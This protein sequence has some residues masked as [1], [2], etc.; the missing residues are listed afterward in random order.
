MDGT[1]SRFDEASG[2]GVVAGA[3][4]R[5]YPFHC[6]QLVDGTRAVPPGAAVRFV[7]MAGHLGR[8]EAAAIERV[9]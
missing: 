4:G 5:A 6:T 2:L 3:D 1:V 9:G 8:W 7:V